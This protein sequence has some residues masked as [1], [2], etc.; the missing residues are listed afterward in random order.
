MTPPGRGGGGGA[1]RSPVNVASWPHWYA[2]NPYLNLLYAALRR[3]GIRHH[4]DVPLDPA[5]MAR[6]PARI[7]AVHLHWLYPYWSEG[8]PNPLLRAGRL[9]RFGRVIRRLRRSGL[10]LV[11]TV[12]NLEP[13][14]GAGPLARRAYRIVHRRA[15][16]RVHHSEWSRRAAEER[17]GPAGPSVVVP[18]GNYEGVYP[19]GP[20]PA[21][22][23]RR[24]GVEPDREL[25]L[26]FG[27]LRPYKGFDLA[28]E[29]TGRLESGRY[30]LVVA[31]RPLEGQAGRLRALSRG[32]PDVTLVLR[33]LPRAD[34]GALLGAADAVLLPYREVTTSGALLAAL[35]AGCAV[36][37]S[38]LPY[39]REVLAGEPDA[40]V[41]VEPGDAAALAAGIVETARVPRPWRSEAARRLAGRYRWDE[42][43]RPLARW[44]RGAAPPAGGG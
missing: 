4:P 1:G 31:G 3:K 34:L 43:V 41:L 5:A 22:A 17:Y 20:S 27:Q 18:H 11:W 39:F 28:V 2:P 14:G 44:L 15:D 9:L 6:H 26:C 16:L 8:D 40:S 12:H 32:R 36:V 13:H 25:L 35:T 42:V 10:R 24:L 38:D 29:A 23:R 33:S 19:A 30:H 21:E 7:D 37:A